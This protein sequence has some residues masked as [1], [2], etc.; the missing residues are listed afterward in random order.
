[1]RGRLGAVTLG[2]LVVTLVSML[3]FDEPITRIIGVV[4]MFTFIISGVF[5][6]ASPS[7]IEKEDEAELSPGSRG[8][9]G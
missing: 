2:A 8:T 9:G 7:Y 1:M 5:L 4:A 6:I 3:F